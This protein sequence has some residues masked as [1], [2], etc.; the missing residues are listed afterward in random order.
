MLRASRELALRE[1]AMFFGELVSIAAIPSCDAK[2]ITSLTNYYSRMADIAVPEL[3]VSPEI[4]N[5]RPV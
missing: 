1:R 3:R 2:Y 5:G 4:K